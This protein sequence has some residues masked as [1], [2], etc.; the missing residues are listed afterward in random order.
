VIQVC[1][2]GHAPG[3]VA[4]ALRLAVA[5]L[6]YL[7]SPAGEVDGPGCGQVLAALGQIQ[8]RFTAAQASVLH[9]FD[10]AGAHDGDG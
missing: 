5:G 7:N 1:T 10:A 9:R 4:D 6:D 3:S 2:S 8:A